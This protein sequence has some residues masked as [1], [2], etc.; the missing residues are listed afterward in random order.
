GPLGCNAPDLVV[1]DSDLSIYTQNI[2][3]SPDACTVYEGCVDGVGWR[4]VLRFDT[5][6]A[7]LG[8]RDLI[9]GV[10]ANH[11][12]LYTYSPCHEHHRF[13]N[14]ASYALLAGERPA[15]VGHKQAFCLLD[16]AA[17]SWPEAGERPFYSCVNQGLSL[18]WSDTYEA[19]LDC[20]WI[21]VT[22]VDP[23]Q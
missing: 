17:W 23:G 8:S 15:A 16:W 14:S 13:Y 18:G 3:V 11:P 1:L 22:D 21:D 10:P 19:S 6:A 2:W 7:N 12:D 20:Q 4:R 5:R 9:L